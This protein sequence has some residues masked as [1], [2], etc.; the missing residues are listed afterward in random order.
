VRLATTVLAL[1]AI[2]SMA[3]LSGY[4][5]PVAASM[6]L[7]GV[8][9]SAD[10]LSDI[11]Y[12]ALQ[13]NERMDVIARSMT[14]RGF[15]SLAAF[16]AVLYATRSLAPAVAALAAARILVLLL[17]DR[18]RGSSGQSLRCSGTGAQFE[19][20][21]TALPLGVVLMLVSLTSNVP[22]YAIEGSL[23]ATDLGIFAA[24]A[25]FL[26]VGSTIVNALGQSATPRLARYFSEGD[27]RQFKGLAWRLTG[28]AVLLGAAGVLLAALLGGLVLGVLYRPDYA[29]YRGLLVWMMAAG[30]CV[31]AA[32]V[33]GYVVTSARSFLAQMPLLGVVAAVSAVASWVLVPRMGLGGAALAV[34]L[35]A[36][37]QIAGEVL[38]LRKA[39]RR[40]EAAR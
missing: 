30:I 34:A 38:I 22:R 15:L 13:R 2:A 4:A 19:I 33:L 28:L 14:A 20:F 29:A 35:A 32:V 31:Y 27:L 25:A 8:S 40:L 3:G 11:Y 5:Y 9:L 21:R 36:C 10:N 17:Y 18:P 26:T 39:L 23:G 7:L 1:A 16:G 6:V 12:G 24:V 37:V